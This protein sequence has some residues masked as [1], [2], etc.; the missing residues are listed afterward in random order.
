MICYDNGY[1][2]T[3]CL[4]QLLDPRQKR[5]GS[6]VKLAAP[7]SAHARAKG[8]IVGPFGFS[9]SYSSFHARVGL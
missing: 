9:Q 3:I 6:G 2:S 8:S 4:T 1:V 5:R 7:R